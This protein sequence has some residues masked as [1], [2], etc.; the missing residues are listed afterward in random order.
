M[1]TKQLPMNITSIHAGL[2]GLVPGAML[3]KSL[4]A[5]SSADKKAPNAVK[6]K[7]GRNANCTV[8]YCH[9]KNARPLDEQQVS[10]VDE[11][12]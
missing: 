2:K 3:R 4:D 5:M 9:E 8:Y 6:C 11:E 10:V 7:V 12:S 1:V